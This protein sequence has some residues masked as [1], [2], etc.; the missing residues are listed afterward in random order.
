MENEQNPPK[1]QRN[2]PAPTPRHDGWTVERQQAFLHA[3][4]ACGVVRQACAAVGMSHV[5]AYTL[6]ARPSAIAF[7]AAWDA[8]LDCAIS[9]VEE[10]AVSRSIHGV[11]RPIFYKGEQVGEWRH[12]DERLTMFLLRFRRS[13]RFG[14]QLDGTP[15][16]NP[17][18]PD[19]A[20]EPMGRLE[21]LLDE[22]T[23]H[24]DPPNDFS[25]R[26]DGGNFGNFGGEK[27]GDDKD[28]DDRGEDDRDEDEGPLS[29]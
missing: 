12:H 21:W 3:L 19:D 29:P 6:R 14:A 17:E 15:A 26:L 28:Q 24:G 11:P 23:D 10:A 27:E 18:D 25:S 22:L 2:L 9:L 7:R 8:A 16:T 5:S 1:P 13:A 4:A 20:E